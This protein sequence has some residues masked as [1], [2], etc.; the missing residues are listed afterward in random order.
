MNLDPIAKLSILNESASSLIDKMK[1][2]TITRRIALNTIIIFWLLLIL[3]SEMTVLEDA[4][5]LITASENTPPRLK[6]NTPKRNT[7]IEAADNSPLL[8]TGVFEPRR[9]IAQ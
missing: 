6:Q 5:G 7:I 8:K 1:N 9:I 4:R 2:G 3:F